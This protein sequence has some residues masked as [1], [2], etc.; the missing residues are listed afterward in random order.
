MT[1]LE[2]ATPVARKQHLCDVC[3]GVIGEGDRYHR[4]RGIWDEGPYTHKAH[5]LCNAAYWLAMRDLGY[6]ARWEEYAEWSEVR[7]YVERF[8]AVVSG[9]VDFGRPAASV[10]RDLGALPTDTSEP[11]VQP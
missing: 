11:A 6:D 1:V 9:S 2:N 5:A 8:F 10:G 4:Q 3:L 7:P